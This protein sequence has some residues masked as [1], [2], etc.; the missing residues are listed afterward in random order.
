MFF[1]VQNRASIENYVVLDVQNAENIVFY[2]VLGL[3]SRQKRVFCD[4]FAKTSYFTWFEA[5]GGEKTSYFTTF[6]ELGRG[7][8]ENEK[9]RKTRVFFALGGLGPKRKSGGLGQR[10]RKLGY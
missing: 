1:G 10:H 3:Q 5:F 9:H 4:V 6:Q 2:V 7:T 8:S